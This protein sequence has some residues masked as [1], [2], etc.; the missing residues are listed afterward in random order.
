MSFCNHKECMEKIEVIAKSMLIAVENDPDKLD[1]LIAET[2]FNFM[3][4][5][6]KQ[7]KKLDRPEWHKFM[8]YFWM[9]RDVA[10]STLVRMERAKN[11]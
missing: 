9:I 4:D 1:D 11:V 2:A 10:I 6:F 5:L 8:S 3:R 7:G